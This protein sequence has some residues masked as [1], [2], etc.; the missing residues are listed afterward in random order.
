MERSDWTPLGDRRSLPWSRGLAALVALQDPETGAWRG[1]SGFKLNS[2]WRVTDAGVPHVGNTALAVEALV[3]GGQRAGA[4][5]YGT[6]LERGVRWLLSCQAP[7]GYLSAHGTRMREHAYA[8]RALSLAATA[9]VALPEGALERAAA[10]SLQAR[11]AGVAGW[12][13]TPR[14]TQTDILETA[15]QLHALEWAAVGLS[16]TLDVADY[17]AWQATLAPA[18]AAALAYIGSLRVSEREA[19]PGSPLQSVGRAGPPLGTFRFMDSPGARVTANTTA[20]GLLAPMD[21]AAWRESLA[22]FETLRERDDW[23]ALG[24]GHFLRWDAELLARSAVFRRD[25]HDH[26]DAPLT[27]ALW[28]KQ[29]EWVLSCATPE[30]LWRCTEGPGDAY[31]TAMACI[32]LA[33]P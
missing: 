33:D 27:R 1:D 6:A 14:A 11:A 13:F 26:P 5:P 16:R 29:V 2:T 19:A 18:R 12:R 31:T 4:A 21:D 17:A 20:A 9:G 7:D 3:R 23:R 8:L 15:H 28:D 25:I 30:G 32:L 10:F 22:A 24:A